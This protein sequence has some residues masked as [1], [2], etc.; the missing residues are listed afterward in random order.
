ME[1]AKNN[2][3]I[4]IVKYETAYSSLPVLTTSVKE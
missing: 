3:Y 4:M 2:Q 1:T